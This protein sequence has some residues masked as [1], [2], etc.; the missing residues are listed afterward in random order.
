MELLDVASAF[1]IETDRIY[2]LKL[3]I[4]AFKHVDAGRAALS[5]KTNLRQIGLFRS[6]AV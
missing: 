6:L 4:A 2:H 1:S 5:D 3:C